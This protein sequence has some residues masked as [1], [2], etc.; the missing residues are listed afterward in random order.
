M[1]IEVIHEPA[2]HRYVVLV[3]GA[4][5]GEASYVTRADELMITHTFID[6]THRNEGLGAVLVHRAIDDIIATST[7]RITSGCWFVTAW[8]GAHPGYVDAARSGGID[9]ELGNTCR[10]VTP[11]R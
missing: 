4:E 6:P 5:A 10:I 7:Q 9:A 3:D 1:A 8:L 2:A 11:E